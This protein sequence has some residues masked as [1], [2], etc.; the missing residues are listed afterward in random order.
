MRPEL[1]W[2]AS[3]FDD[4]P[5]AVDTSFAQLRRIDLDDR[6]WVDYCPG[7]LA[8][9]D[10]V[11]ALLLRSARWQQR[12][13][14][15]YERKLPEP[16]LTAGWQVGDEPHADAYTAA[17]GRVD[18]DEDAVGRTG[19]DDAATPPVLREIAKR[20]SERYRVG[21]DSIWVNLYRDGR[22]SVAWHGDRNARTQVNPLVATVS[23][24]GRRAFLLRPRAGTQQAGRSDGPGRRVRLDPGHGDL[25]VMGGACQHDW[26]HTVPKTS[27]PVAPRMSVT[28]RH[29]AP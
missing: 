3:L 14:W 6:S 26:L 1:A 23:L 8:G 17:A 4:G 15:M 10:E 5:A 16:R 25:V 9:S 11:F 28:I 19:V 29:S 13:V 21:F 20:L 18:D 24:G 2:Q 27:K 12:E 22:D 7:W